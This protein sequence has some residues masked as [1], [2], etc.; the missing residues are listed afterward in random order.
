[1]ARIKGV[2][3]EEAPEE[4]RAIFEEQ[5]KRY[6]FV[7]NTA[8]VYALRPT[9]Q[10]GVQALAQGIVASGLIEPDLRHLLCVK[11]ANINGCPF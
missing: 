3:K 9:I 4:V 7:S 2:T 6:G 10:Q 1:M 11:T 5:E 8:R